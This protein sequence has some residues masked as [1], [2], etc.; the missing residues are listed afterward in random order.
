MNELYN[1]SMANRPGRVVYHQLVSR[2]TA[3]SGCHPAQYPL[4]RDSLGM[5]RL[6]SPS[7]HWGMCTP[8]YAYLV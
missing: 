4:T 2:K 5:P 1:V 6:Q 3:L 8:M 7:R